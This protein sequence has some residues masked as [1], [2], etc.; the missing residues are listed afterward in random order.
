MFMYKCNHKNNS[1]FAVNEDLYYYTQ[2]PYLITT[3]N[4]DPGVVLHF[5]PDVSTCTKTI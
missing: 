5:Y 2:H 3:Q 4:M 1:S